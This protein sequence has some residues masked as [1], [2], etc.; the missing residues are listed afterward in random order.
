M[1]A[2]GLVY[3]AERSR[4]DDEEGT[5][6]DRLGFDI[7]GFGIEVDFAA[8]C[9]CETPTLDG[10]EGSWSKT[11]ISESSPSQVRSMAAFSML[12]LE[13]LSASRCASSPEPHAFSSRALLSAAC[14]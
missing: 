14:A 7:D 4:D 2:L 1:L 8:L 13:A 3:G 6:G 9:D 11:M 10:T 12:S 5:A